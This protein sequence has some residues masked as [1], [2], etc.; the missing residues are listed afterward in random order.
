[1][2]IENEKEMAESGIAL[3]LTIVLMNVLIL[4]VLVGMFWL[5][6]IIISQSNQLNDL[7][8]GFNLM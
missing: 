5:V 8:R 1:M 2:R 3:A 6:Q 4:S 7:V